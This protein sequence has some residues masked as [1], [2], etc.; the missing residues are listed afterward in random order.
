MLCT[1]SFASQLLGP[2]ISPAIAYKMFAKMFMAFWKR[3][4]FTLP[5]FCTSIVRTVA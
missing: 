4:C 5:D 1:Q 3:T 2:L